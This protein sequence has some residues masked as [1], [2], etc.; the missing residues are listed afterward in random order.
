MVRV[1]FRAILLHLIFN[2]VYSNTHEPKIVT[3]WTHLHAHCRYTLTTNE[4]QIILCQLLL[5]AILKA[6]LGSCLTILGMDNFDCTKIKLCT[7]QKIHSLSVRG[8]HSRVE[9]CNASPTSPPYVVEQ[10][11]CSVPHT[12]TVLLS[13]V[14]VCSTNDKSCIPVKAQPSTQSTGPRSPTIG[15]Q[16][17]SQGF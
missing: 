9:A 11:T 12:T 16:A 2:W 17:R 15:L 8:A 13:C 4:L 10:I 7:L 5:R 1:C 14:L 6:R 3:Q